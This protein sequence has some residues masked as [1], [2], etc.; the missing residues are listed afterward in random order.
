MREIELWPDS[1]KRS[2]RLITDMVMGGVSLGTL[3]TA[4]IGEDA[5]VRMRGAVSTENNGGFI[6]IA[7]D[8]Q[9]AGGAFDASAFTG[10]GLEVFGN[11]ET[12]GMHL[13]TTDVV[14]PQQSYRSAFVAPQ[15]RT[16]LKLPFAGFVPHR[17][18][19]PFNSSRLRRIGLVAIGRAFD[20]DLSVARVWLY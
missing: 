18:E 2:W 19:T 9:P 11:G 14:R 6:Q 17:I 12:Y 15:H 20:A 1:G 5:P 10:I 4:T 7:L 3:H 16:L 13:R 8:L